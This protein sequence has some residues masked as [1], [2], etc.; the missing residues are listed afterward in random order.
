MLLQQ[1]DKMFYVQ[2]CFEVLITSGTSTICNNVQASTTYTSTARTFTTHTFTFRA[3]IS[4]TFSTRLSTTCTSIN[5]SNKQ[6]AKYNFPQGSTAGCSIV[7]NY[8]SLCQR[9]CAQSSHWLRCC[10]FWNS[11]L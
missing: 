8:H 2:T 6:L 9:P 1:I 10:V 5:Q 3:Y 11:T 4:R 7:M